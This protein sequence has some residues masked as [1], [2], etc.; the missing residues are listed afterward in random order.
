MFFIL[1]STGV[2]STGSASQSAKR[3]QTSSIRY[4]PKSFH[5][6]M[7]GFCHGIILK[8]RDAQL[9]IQKN[10]FDSG[11]AP[12]GHTHMS[13][14]T[15]SSNCILYHCTRYRAQNLARTVMA[16][17]GMAV[18]CDR[19]GGSLRLVAAAA[20]S[21]SSWLP[22]SDNDSAVPD[23]AARVPRRRPGPAPPGRAQ[24]Q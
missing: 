12:P 23:S 10:S 8:F 18:C 24:S 15:F 13:E 14:H 11:S 5:S 1:T 16:H 4:I 20:H 3:M 7:R 21:S 17:A 2:H 6:P 22:H 9:C 19:V